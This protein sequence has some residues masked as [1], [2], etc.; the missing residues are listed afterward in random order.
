MQLEYSQCK[1]T[2]IETKRC[3]DIENQSV[4]LFGTNVYKLYLNSIDLT[5]N[6]R[7]LNTTIDG[8][9][10]FCDIWGK[11]RWNTSHQPRRAL[12]DYF[13]NNN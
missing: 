4:D 9:Q 1:L 12:S 6:Q 3:L 2:L 8:R 11:L 10:K 7:T 13:K 5:S